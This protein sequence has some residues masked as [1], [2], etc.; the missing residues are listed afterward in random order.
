MSEQAAEREQRVT[1]LEL[2]FDL[3]FAFGFTQV[4][5]VLSD[6]PTWSGLGHGLLILAALW[7]AWAA[8]AWLTNTIDPEAGAVWG[9]ILVA[10]AAMFVAALAVPEAFGRHGVVF[11]VAFL[12]VNVM[13]LALYALGARGDADLLGA[14]L[15][16]APM[17]LAGASIILAAGFLHGALRPLF[18][19]AAIAIGLFGPV[20]MDMSGWRVQPAHF[21]ERHGLIVIIAIGESLIATGLGA[22]STALGTGVIVAAVLGLVVVNS[23]WLA[24]FDFFPAR[25]QQLLA[26]RSGA[27]RA[28]LAR[29]VYTYLH[30]PMVAG[31]VLFA[32]AMRTTLAH[33]GSR[34]DT[35]PAFAL[36][37][38]PALYLFAYVALRWRVSRTFGRGRLVAAIACAL[39]FPVAL[40][41]PALVALALLA[42]VWV[43]LHAY[44]IIWWRE[45]RARTRALRVPPPP[46]ELTVSPRSGSR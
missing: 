5:I 39:L 24:Y 41:V 20:L 21:I 35:I 22:R 33:V 2:F 29:D 3:V 34:L 8:Y 45:A 6:S 12:L 18:W 31:I 14:I 36:C 13:F 43:A 26:D 38:G 16:I 46:P 19:L 23:F 28:A 25:G 10:M 32:F 9:P 40:A 42:A 11:G 7:W 17:A 30:L 15:R 44:E 37:A 27:Q 1:P 4:T